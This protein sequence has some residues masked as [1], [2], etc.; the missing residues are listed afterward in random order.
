MEIKEAWEI[1]VNGMEVNNTSLL[2][3]IKNIVREDTAVL[4]D[5]IEEARKEMTS[6]FIKLGYN[7]E[8]L[9]TEIKY[10]VNAFENGYRGSIYTYVYPPAHPG[11]YRMKPIVY[12]A[13]RNYTSEFYTKMRNEQGKLI[14]EQMQIMCRLSKL[15]KENEELKRELENAQARIRELQEQCPEE[16]EEP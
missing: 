7:E 12:N 11:V 10:I 16:Q 4:K 9:E 3:Q 14:K 1:K 15:I 13:E 6:E 2:E 8:E 5:N